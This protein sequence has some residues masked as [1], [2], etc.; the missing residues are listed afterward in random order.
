[1]LGNAVSLV[2][3][4][5]VT[6]FTVFNLTM[7]LLLI[8]KLITIFQ[9][10]VSINP[11]PDSERGFIIGTACEVFARNKWYQGKVH[12]IYNK[13]NTDQIWIKVAVYNDAK[14]IGYIDYHEW[15]G[16]ISMTTTKQDIMVRAIDYQQPINGCNGMIEQC[17]PT[18]RI[19]R[20]LQVYQQHEDDQETFMAFVN[21]KYNQLLNDWTHFTSKHNDS[22][23]LEQVFDEFI[24]E[25]EHECDIDTCPLAAH[26]L[27][28]R[29]ADVMKKDTY[30]ADNT[31]KFFIDLMNAIH[32]NLYHLWD[33]GLR[34]RDCEQSMAD[35]ITKS[36]SCEMRKMKGLINRRFTVSNKFDI[37]TI[38]ADIT[39]ILL[40]K[41][42]SSIPFNNM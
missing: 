40:F 28:D 8:D 38:S 19:I 36:K 15:N 1:M 31:T 30:N 33:A 27:R 20:A 32:Y 10:R 34:I 23:Q 35:N 13:A 22:Y 17:T 24:A 6:D 12:Q 4:G 29:T 37:C 25:S 39:G 42:S 26:H 5:F 18:R 41:I 2:V 7:A 3:V 21:E 14:L 9:R 11:T 16:N